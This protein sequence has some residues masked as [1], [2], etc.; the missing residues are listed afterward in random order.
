MSS[1]TLRALRSLLKHQVQ[2]LESINQRDWIFLV[3]VDRIVFDI[4][5]SQKLMMVLEEKQHLSDF[6]AFSLKR[7]VHCKEIQEE[8]RM[9]TAQKG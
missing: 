6:P 5:Q 2:R 8:T 7:S 9:V 1:Q 4:L 3:I